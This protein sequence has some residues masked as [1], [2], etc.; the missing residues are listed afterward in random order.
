MET[1]I[2]FFGKIIDLIIAAIWPGT[3]IFIVF[4]FKSKLS[5]LLD[6]I[7]LRFKS[8]SKLELPGGI[9]A[10]FE[11]DDSE[12]LTR[13]VDEISNGLVEEKFSDKSLIKGT[14]QKAFFNEKLNILI[15]N[16]IASRGM[17]NH[18]ELFKNVGNSING[19]SS[20]E[21]DMSI[22]NLQDSNLVYEN[23]GKIL[24]T[25]AGI[26]YLRKVTRFGY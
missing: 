1:N 25:S 12:A 15:L 10:F 21:F 23:N 16:L 9:K 14:I 8:T 20:S 6:N 7:I 3:I 17:I 18:N 5:A 22:K 4:K 24:V 13:V 11:A 2:D 19:I 26:D